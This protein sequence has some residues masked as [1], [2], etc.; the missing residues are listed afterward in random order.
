MNGQ[1]NIKKSYRFQ[2]WEDLHVSTSLSLEADFWVLI[3]QNE[4]RCNNIFI[5]LLDRLENPGN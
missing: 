4:P 1:P 5:R 2:M 3:L